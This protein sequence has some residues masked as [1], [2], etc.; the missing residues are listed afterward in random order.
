MVPATQLENK[1][2]EGDDLLWTHGSHSLRFGAS[3]LRQDTNVFPVRADQPGASRVCRSSRQAETRRQRVR[4]TPLGPQYYPYRNFREIDFSPY[5]QDDWK[6]TSKLTLN[7]GVR[8]EFATNPVDA[9]N[10]LASPT[11]LTSTS[12]VKVPHAFQSNP[13]WRN[14]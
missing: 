5:V 3:I 10:A 14:S 8:W 2:A 6:V 13:S 9:N 4:G 12:F 11:M 7:L 1:F